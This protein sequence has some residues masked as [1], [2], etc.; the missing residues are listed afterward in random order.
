MRRSWTVSLFRHQQPDGAAWR[1]LERLVTAWNK[2]RER[3]A[4]RF[5]PVQD[6]MWHATFGADARPQLDRLL[7]QLSELAARTD[8]VH[9]LAWRDRVEEDD[10][11]AADFIEILGVDP[12]LTP[13][14][15]VNAETALLPGPPCPRCGSQDALDGVQTE[16]FRIDERRLH[17]RGPDVP[18]GAGGWD[19]VNLPNG[20]LVVSRRFAAVLA[21]NHVRGYRLHE[22]I[23]AATGRSSERM[24]H[25][26]AERAVLT[27]CPEH[28]RIDGDPFCPECGTAFGTLDGYFWARADLVG[29]DEVLS[30]HPGRGAML[31][32]SRR[33]HDALRE[34]GLNGVRRNNVLMLCHHG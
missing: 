16:P 25:L 7:G 18:P 11:A 6:F 10:F 23:D 3:G 1:A 12:M 30:R 2:G 9:H 31:H 4:P 21:D 29:D 32:V 27:P 19:A 14:F 33:V 22:V 13:P 34:A 28:S 26:T 24:V 17:D 5:E 15:L 20:H 8:A